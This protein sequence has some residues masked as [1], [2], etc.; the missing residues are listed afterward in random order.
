MHPHAWS[1]LYTA[2]TAYATDDLVV[3]AEQAVLAAQADPSSLLAQ[4]AATYLARAANEG[5]AAVYVSGE[6]F[7]AFI[8][9]GGNL[10]LY[11]AVSA[12]LRAAYQ[13]APLTLLDIGVGDGMALLPALTSAISRVDLV[14]P[15]AAMLGRTTTELQQQGIAFR[16]FTLDLQTFIQRTQA[17]WDLVQATFSLQS[18]PPAE[19]R[20]CLN[21]LAQHA[22]RLLIAEFDVPE[23]GAGVNPARAAYF[24][25]RYEHGLAEYA[26]IPN[27]ELVAQ[28][29]LMPVFFGYFDPGVARAN[30]EQPISAWEADLRQAGFRQIERHPLYDY[31]WAPAYL[32]EARA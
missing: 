29:F 17:R 25:E 1:A 4:A 19:R 21:W 7:G 10:P 16:A 32:L 8:R 20:T 9:G 24:A 26:Q 31:W 30:Y 11:A 6:A 2:L 18:L 3:A 12:A 23:L 5:K 13:P 27:G 15:S 28:G 14:E 22:P